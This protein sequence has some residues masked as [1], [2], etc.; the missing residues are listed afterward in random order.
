MFKWYLDGTVL[1][2]LIL[3]RK[4]Y[5]IKILRNYETGK[6]FYAVPEGEGWVYCKDVFEVLRV[7]KRKGF[8][9]AFGWSLGN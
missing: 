7:L 1:A 3:T 2:E 4:D 8:K 5:K 6:W 9:H